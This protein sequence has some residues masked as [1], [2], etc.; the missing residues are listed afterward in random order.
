MNN[1]FAQKITLFEIRSGTLGWPC[2][3][4]WDYFNKF[5][6]IF[7]NSFILIVSNRNFAQRKSHIWI[8]TLQTFCLA[9]L[10]EVRKASRS[11]DRVKVWRQKY[12]TSDHQSVQL[13]VRFDTETLFHDFLFMELHLC[14]VSLAKLVYMNDF[15]KYTLK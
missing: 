10:N 8:V 11:S 2:H 9:M 6:G 7:E 5:S 12:D 4:D 13:L 1:N 15:L 14:K 3:W